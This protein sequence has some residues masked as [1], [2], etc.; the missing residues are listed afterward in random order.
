MRLPTRLPVHHPAH[1]WIAATV[2]SVIIGFIAVGARSA[3]GLRSATAE[4]DDVL[5]DTLYHWRT[6]EDR[7]DGSVVIL[8]INETALKEMNDGLLNGRHLG[9]PW[10]RSTWALL[11]PYLER[12]GAK[13]VVFDVLFDE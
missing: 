8:A 11:L 4:A 13:A 5:Y 2:M 6:P 12:H 3:P 10:P 9:W 7:R 1:K